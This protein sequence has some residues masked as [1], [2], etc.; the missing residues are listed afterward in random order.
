M[1]NNSN[2]IFQIGNTVQT[3]IIIIN[4]KVDA[5]IK[6]LK[7]DF[8]E[9][10][11]TQA[12][13][14]LNALLVENEQNKA[15]KYQL[16]LVKISFLMQFR[17]MNDFQEYL[18]LITKEYCEF[19]DIKY[20]ELKLTLMSFLGEEDFFSYSKQLR[21]ETPNSKP[22]GH[23]DI[24]YYLNS[25][26][27]EK[28]K[29]IFDIE[30]QNKNYRKH[31]LLIGGHIYSNLY[32]YGEENTTYFKLAD[33]YYKEVLENKNEISFM[34]KLHI[35]GF[36]GIIY[37]NNELRYKKQNI[38]VEYLKNYKSLLDVVFE[39]KKYFDTKYI[40]SLL[41][42]YIHALLLL[43]FI[44]EYKKIYEENKELLA[45]RFYFQYCEITNIAFEHEK[46]QTYIKKDFD[47]NDL[48]IYVSFINNQNLDDTKSIISF[49]DE[50][51]DFI[52]KNNFVFYC[53]IQGI[54]QLN[55]KINN[56]IMDYLK[57]NKHLSIDL[58][59][60][61][62][63]V[64]RYN[65]QQLET[66]DLEKLFDF[67]NQEN[68]FVDKIINTMIFLQHIGNK[69]YLKIA[70]NKQDIFEELIFEALKLCRID[71]DLNYNQFNDFTE[72]IKSK[73]RVYLEIAQIYQKF[74]KLNKAFDFYYLQYEKNKDI[75]VM[76]YIL[77]IS[78][79]LYAQSGEK[80][81]AKKQN[82][83]FNN[84]LTKIDNLKFQDL[85][86]ILSYEISV[87]KSSKD[88]LYLI[89][90]HLL[91]TDIE[92]IDKE[93]KIKLSN[94]YTQTTIGMHSNYDQL[95]IYEDNICYEKDGKTYLK[96]YQVSEENKNN[97]G[98]IVVDKNKFFTIKNDSKYRQESL[99]HRIIGPFA[100]RVNNP[101]LIPI[102]INLDGK[103]PL[104]EF[105][106]FMD[107][108][109]QQEKEL[110]L[111]YT[112]EEF[113]GLYP[114]SKHNYANYF[115]LIPYLLEHKDYYLNSL[116]PSFII[117]R[118]KILTLSS[119][120]FL[121]YLGHLDIVLKMKNIVIQQTTINW[122]QEYIEKYSP[123]HR[124][125]NFSYMDEEKPKFIP[126]T[127]EEEKKTIKFKDELIGLTKKLLLCEIVNDTKENLPIAGAYKILA[128]EMG[129]QE[130][131]ALAYCIN[132]NYQIISENNI[133]EILFDKFGYNKF[134]I[135]N[136]FALLTNILD[137]EEVYNLQQKLFSNNYKYILN[138]PDINRILQRLNYGGF[139][140]ILNNQ[141]TLYFN[142]WYKYGCLDKLIKEYVAK[143][144]VLYPKV[145]LPQRD[146]FSNNMEYLLE[147]LD[148]KGKCDNEARRA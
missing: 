4:V 46:V 147:I 37:I 112:N 113:Y 24:I 111:K 66:I 16:L 110:F 129:V 27:N 96:G 116:K 34:E 137:E 48:I 58:L 53:Y 61:F 93:I 1:T 9:G 107:K 124:P 87:R 128:K 105:L 130:Y 99:F 141:L 136:S 134:F 146:T 39:N 118:K 71:R 31:L 86:F 67:I 81:E 32:Q 26:N 97:F 3:N 36:Y 79:V 20:K 142:I 117:D 80:Y 125:T 57:E 83:I 108:I 63:E 104:S 75:N 135:S 139:K 51:I 14:F 144:K 11:F 52:Y 40:N 10:S 73:D 35:Y 62:L 94:L 60:S 69:L 42:N 120:V 100:F 84:I 123:I 17:Q 13:N 38:E 138:C 15:V 55:K 21:L 82:E 121:N 41:E 88:I 90:Q 54:I 133:F 56:E 25:G 33:K 68:N 8:D 119:I 28:A 95:F 127:K 5:S 2:S 126:Y 132:H 43:G 44:K 70:L 101:N 6:R 103:N 106:S 89:N 115:T 29:E 72:N 148:L 64:Q 47:I 109:N 12:I 45:I 23:F 143:Y 74:N 7:K 59:L 114:L 65:Q 49:L 30:I 18:E 98:F 131:H 78:L 77:D 102:K 91:N 19:I 50:N 140:N 22:Q 145:I 76:F 122:L 85:L 92:N